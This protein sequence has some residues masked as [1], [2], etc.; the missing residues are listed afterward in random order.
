MPQ[1]QPGP[2]LPGGGSAAPRP[3]LCAVP[4]SR[5]RAAWPGWGVALG[6]ERHLGGA[7]A[8]PCPPFPGALPTSPPPGPSASSLPSAALAP[9]L[10]AS[11]CF[12]ASAQIPFPRKGC[13]CLHPSYLYS[14]AGGPAQGA[15]SLPRAHGP[16]CLVSLSCPPSGTHT[17]GQGQGALVGSVARGFLGASRP[18]C[19]PEASDSVAQTAGSCP[20]WPHSQCGLGTAKGP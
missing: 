4:A 10:D 1:P 15:P 9:A 5:Q 19:R 7:K 13:I 16:G 14:L 8:H 20:Q 17:V 11:V 2:S 18:V 12:P 6:V 3:E